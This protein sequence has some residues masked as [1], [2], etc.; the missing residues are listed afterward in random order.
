MLKLCT[1]KQL[2]APIDN[3]RNLR[4]TLTVILFSLGDGTSTRRCQAQIT[5]EFH[6]KSIL[7]TELL[8]KTP[9]FETKSL[10]K[11]DGQEK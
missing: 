2:H 8:N 7:C 3:S 1:S 10:D 6:F 5:V 11:F 4:S 9:A